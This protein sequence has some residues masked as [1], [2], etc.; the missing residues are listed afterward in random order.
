MRMCVDINIPLWLRKLGQFLLKLLNFVCLL[1]K[2]A[3]D[4]AL[5]VSTALQPCALE[6]P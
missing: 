6:S 2:F 3:I 5:S 1:A 4:F